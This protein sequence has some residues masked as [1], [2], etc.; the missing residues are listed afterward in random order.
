MAMGIQ[1]SSV[2]YV[3]K[4]LCYRTFNQ[5]LTFTISMFDCLYYIF[6]FRVQL[7]AKVRE[8]QLTTWAELL[9]KY[10]KHINQVNL[11][12]NDE[13]SPLFFNEPLNRRLNSE[14]RQLILEHLEQTGHASALD[15]KKTEWEIYWYTLDELGNML[16][17]WASDSGH[18]GS[19][20]TLYE[21]SKGDDAAGQD[22]HG[23]DENVLLKALQK[24]ETT[25]KCEVISFDDNQG[26]KFF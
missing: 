13:S 25:G 23:I 20:C 8:Q 11:N 4:Y 16:Y 26:V 17:K 3:R 2:L 12:V 21:L 24:L 14:G 5:T 9:L 1:F 7:H 10:Q 15:K 6:F 18:T 22:F 19:V